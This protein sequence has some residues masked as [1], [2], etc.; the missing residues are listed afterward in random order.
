MTSMAE[1]VRGSASSGTGV[2]L[3]STLVAIALLLVIGVVMA[4]GAV[5]YEEGDL[6]KLI[7]ALGPVLG[8]ITG[9][10]VTY[11]FT[12]SAVAASTQ[13]ATVS[14]ATAAGAQAATQT[15]EE[16]ERAAHARGMDL[17][18]A[19]TE[20]FASLPVEQAEKLKSM[21]AVRKVLES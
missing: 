20:I 10:F 8:V 9:G 16:N 14:A 19:L 3:G 15:A 2:T 17:H 21:S 6:A 12:K 13:S 5:R 18:N 11:F 7:G 1:R 4:I